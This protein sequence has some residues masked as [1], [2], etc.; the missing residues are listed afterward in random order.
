[1]TLTD[2]QIFHLLRSDETVQLQKKIE[3]RQILNSTNITIVLQDFHS[4]S[5]ESTLRSIWNTLHVY[6]H[7][8]FLN[9]L[10]QK[11]MINQ[12]YKEPKFP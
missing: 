2:H 11:N 10:E 7:W 12:T 6:H 3:I 9:I 8:V 5:T 4:Q 1:M